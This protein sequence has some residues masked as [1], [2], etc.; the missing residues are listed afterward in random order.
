MKNDDK[1]TS[2]ESLILKNAIS[3]LRIGLEDYISSSTDQDRKLSS[4]RNIYA[5]LLL[6]LKAGL[7][8]Y[9]PDGSNDV[10]I[11]A[12]ILP[13]R[14]KDTGISFIGTEKNTVDVKGIRD[15]YN[16]LGINL[17]WDPL[18][19]IQKERNNIEHFYSSTPIETIQALVCEASKFILEILKEVFETDPSSMLGE[20]WNKMIAI[21]NIYEPIK[22]D[23]N[24]SLDMLSKIISFNP[25]TI[26]LLKELRCH[27]CNSPLLYFDTE[28]E[29]SRDG[30]M[31]TEYLDSLDLACYSCHATEPVYEALER[32]A[33]DQYEI[34]IDEAR[35]GFGSVIK[36]CPN[37][38]HET[39]IDTY[40]VNKCI[41]CGYEKDYDRCNVCERLLSLEEQ[42]LD[43][44]CFDCEYAFSKLEDED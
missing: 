15:R 19:K 29:I 8:H 41:L 22:K 35:A 30:T 20:V 12:K 40:D 9:S 14:N 6:F 4:V 38:E 17:K 7:C 43:G 10:L 1:T 31:Y 21:K 18:E 16:S 5:S 26:S 37:C 33:D 23:C 32:Y 3:S 36:E 44:L 27:E 39:F 11:K 28:S 25:E 2:S 24:E 13:V 42:E 34:S